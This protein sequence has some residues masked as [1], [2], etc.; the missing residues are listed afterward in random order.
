MPRCR[1][2]AGARHRPSSHSGEPWRSS[3]RRRH[4]APSIPG[5]RGQDR[6]HHRRQLRNRQ[7]AGPGAR[8]ARIRPVPG[9]PKAG[10]AGA[11]PR[12]D[13]CSRSFAA[14]RGPPARRHGRCRRR[15]GDRGSGGKA[16]P[17]RH[18]GGQ[19]GSRELRAGWR[20]PHGAR[21]PGDRDEPDWRDG[22][23]RRGG[24]AVSAPGWRPG[25]GDRVR[26]GSPRPAG[27]G[28]YS[29]SKA[30]LAVYLDSV[31]AET[32]REPIKV[33]TIA[34]GYIDTPINQDAKSR[35]FLI[36]VRKGARITADLIERGA[37]TPR[38]PGSPGPWSRRC[39]A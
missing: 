13:R 11:P 33:T 9:R 10:R 23:R 8:R 1:A 12:R 34:P 27:S 19:R 3:S 4:I 16:R 35:P 26:R 21:P 28:S 6:L 24:G 39:Y 38:F 30:G 17:M 5:V 29:A 37:D 20:R 7:G 32:H 15:G 25:R 22:D 36:D 18:R 2:G 14:G 31:R